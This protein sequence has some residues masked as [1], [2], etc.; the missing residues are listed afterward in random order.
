MNPV[1]M[2][3]N[4]MLMARADGELADEEMELLEDRRAG[5]GVSREQFELALEATKSPGAALRLNA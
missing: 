3:H 2:L 4:L 1:D 5:W